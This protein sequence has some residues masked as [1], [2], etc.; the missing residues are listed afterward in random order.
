MKKLS[1]KLENFR[2]NK[3]NQIKIVQRKSAISERMQGMSLT[4]DYESWKKEWKNWELNQKKIFRLKR[5]ET[6]E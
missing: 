5:S 6:K 4:A 1:D 2:N 3:R